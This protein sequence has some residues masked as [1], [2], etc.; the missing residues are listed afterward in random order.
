MLYIVK[1]RYRSQFLSG[2][3]MVAMNNEHWH[4]NV[5]RSIEIS[6]T[7][8]FLNLDAEFVFLLRISK[9]VLVEYL[10][11]LSDGALRRVHYVE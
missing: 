10:V 1:T 7:I 9:Y 2:V 8:L 6:D 11:S 3:V 4:I 5:V